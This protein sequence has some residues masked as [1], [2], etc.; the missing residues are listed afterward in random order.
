MKKK[1]KEGCKNPHCHSGHLGNVCIYGL[2]FIGAVIYFLSNTT[3][4]WNGVL[5]ILK[6]IVWPVFLVLELF[7]FLGI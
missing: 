3:G 4:F 5:G 6:A 2:G 7:K 1:I